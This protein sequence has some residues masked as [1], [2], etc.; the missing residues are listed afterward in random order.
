MF[1][2][3]LIYWW[4]GRDED[5]QWETLRSKNVTMDEVRS[6]VLQLTKVARVHALERNSAASSTSVYKPWRMPLLCNEL[7]G[8]LI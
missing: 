2:Q 3:H 8:G 7:N 1:E 4:R 6:L 5:E